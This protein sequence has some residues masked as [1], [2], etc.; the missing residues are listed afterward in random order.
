MKRPDAAPVCV[1]IT[2][3]SRG[4]GAELAQ[5]Y[6]ARGITLGL[7][8]RDAGR[9]ERVAAS[10]RALGAAVTVAALDVR[11]REAMADWLA[12]F[13][14][15]SPVE[16]IVANAGVS[17][18]VGANGAPETAAD[19]FRTFDVNLG[20]AVNSIAPLI[21]PMC[22]R[23]R[24]HI[25]VMCSLAALFPFPNTP[26]YS[27]SKAGL[28]VWAEALGRAHRG[29]GLSVSV[30]CPGFVISHMSDTVVGPRPLMVSAAEAV[31]R[32]RNGLDRRKRMIA[33][34]ALLRWG[35]CFLSLLPEAVQRPLLVL[36]AYRVRGADGA[37]GEGPEAP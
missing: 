34:P 19:A 12:R 3:A 30:I 11:D 22:R 18:S 25:A 15:E 37:A 24:G 31:R 27:A 6:A 14:A 17:S 4:I 5:S 21:G 2:G 23:G 8:G 29:A 1:V 9:L 33:F 26:S 28:K 32:I 13:D 10:C 16:L 7:L 20:G 35:I 36:F